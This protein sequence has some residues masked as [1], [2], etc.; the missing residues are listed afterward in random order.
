MSLQSLTN[1]IPAHLSVFPSGTPNHWTTPY[2]VSPELDTTS[3]MEPRFFTT[4]GKWPF[5]CF[6]T[7][8][9]PDDN[10]QTAANSCGLHSSSRRLLA[11]ETKSS[12]CAWWRVSGHVSSRLTV[13]PLLGLPAL[14]AP[15]SLLPYS[16]P[17]SSPGC[18]S[19]CTRPTQPR[20]KPFLDLPRT[21]MKNFSPTPAPGSIAP[22]V[23]GDYSAT[24]FRPG[25]T[26]VDCQLKAGG[27]DVR[28]SLFL[29]V[30]NPQEKSRMRLLRMTPDPVMILL[31][32]G[33]L[34][35]LRL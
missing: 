9:S 23:R 32:N 24:G 4:A 2:T 1:S 25:V 21:T 17:V 19:A 12:S 6:T 30:P 34:K 7:T 14:P 13:P 3:T 16:S 31:P 28:A 18:S 20:Q 35:E 11:V 5:L 22:P 10:S 8:R 27:S 26:G 29:L 15:P 33:V